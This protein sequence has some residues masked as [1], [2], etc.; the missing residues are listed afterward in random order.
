MRQSIIPIDSLE[1]R[2]GNASF[3]R[4]VMVCG[5]QP[6]TVKAMR[7]IC[8]SC[9]GTTVYMS[10]VRSSALQIL[11]DVTSMNQRSAGRAMPHSTPFDEGTKQ[12]SWQSAPS[13]LDKAALLSSFG[14]EVTELVNRST[15]CS[16][17][18]FTIGTSKFLGIPPL[19]S[20]CWLNQPTITRK[21]MIYTRFIKPMHSDKS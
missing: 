19:L 10:F 7:V 12:R 8:R 13:F 15:S 5:D 3:W 1:D 20:S 4:T 16:P 21:G 11:L 2:V 18:A 6:G 17:R 9:Y 14:I